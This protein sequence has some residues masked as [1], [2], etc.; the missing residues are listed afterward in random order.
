[1]SNNAV[2][3]SS[4]HFEGRH[5]QQIILK[6]RDMF[7]NK[8]GTYTPTVSFIDSGHD[9]YMMQYTSKKEKF[10]EVFGIE[11]VKFL[12][13]T[14]RYTEEDAFEALSSDVIFLGGGN[15][16]LFLALLKHRDIL[17]SLKA[18]KDDVIFM[19]TSA[20]SI[21]CTDSIKIA[22]FADSNSVGL[23]DL[24]SI[25]L[26][27]ISFKP[28]FEGWKH[29][30]DDFIAYSKENNKTVYGVNEGEC[31]IIDND[32]VLE[33]GCGMTKIVNGVVIG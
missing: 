21:I 26:C 8:F 5:G 27:D 4:F 22:G 19:G 3:F 31:I 13:L 24:S 1:M 9:E 15:T 20:G 12:D 2:L 33:Y 7:L 11:E 25:G 23:K 17:D 32:R 18:I 14:L 6:V 10:K 30:I 29:K 16:F 28:H